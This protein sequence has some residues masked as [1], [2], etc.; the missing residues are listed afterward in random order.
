[1]LSSRI[2]TLLH[3]DLTPS[4]V[5]SNAGS[6]HNSSHNSSLPTR[7]QAIKLSA[8][9]SMRSWTSR[10]PLSSQATCRRVLSMGVA[11]CSW[12]PTIASKGSQWR[13]LDQRLCSTVKAKTRR[14]KALSG[15]IWWKCESTHQ[16]LQTRSAWTNSTTACGYQLTTATASS[17]SSS[18]RTCKLQLCM[19]LRLRASIHVQLNIRSG[20]TFLIIKSPSAA[21]SHTGF[22]RSL[23]FLSESPNTPSTENIWSQRPRPYKLWR[24]I[25]SSATQ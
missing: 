18:T 2:C 10:A 3:T 15:R 4:V 21:T 6:F 13:S 9:P 14:T 19:S 7:Q 16:T 1:M 12:A 23:S 5:H 17:T 8:H 11:S 25:R 24:S 20:K 22:Q